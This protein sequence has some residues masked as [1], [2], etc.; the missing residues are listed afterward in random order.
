MAWLTGTYAMNSFMNPNSI[1]NRHEESHAGY[2]LSSYVHM[3]SSPVPRESPSFM[4]LLALA[5]SHRHINH[6]RLCTTKPTNHTGQIVNWM[7]VTGPVTIII[8]I[9]IIS[10]CVLGSPP[11]ERS[12]FC[13]RVCR[14]MITMV[15]VGSAVSIIKKGMGAVHRV[16]VA[17][18]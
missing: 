4:S 7:A 15:W 13:S 16:C 5:P 11:L 8:I 10:H 18:E 9:I 2:V 14:K 3:K 1:S 6:P 12:L 17:V